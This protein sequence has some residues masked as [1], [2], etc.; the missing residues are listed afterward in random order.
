M[1][2]LI[3]CIL[4]AGTERTQIIQ[5]S[6]GWNAVYL[7]VQPSVSKPDQA[8]S[9]TPVIH[10]VTYYPSDSPVQFIQDPA[11][12]PWDKGGWNR[13]VPGTSPQA[14]LNNIYNLQANQAYL[15]LCSADYVW[16]VTGTPV[17]KSS[18]TWQPDSF[19]LVGF[20]VDETAPPT[21]SQYF[22][23]SKAHTPLKVYT[24]TDNVWVPV[25]NPDESMIVSGKA[26]WVWC[27]GGSRFPGPLQ[28]T[29]SAGN[30]GLNFMEN[31]SQGQ[32]EVMN[33]SSN[34]LSFSINPIANEAGDPDI[35]LSLVS[36]TPE[37]GSVYTPFT[38]YN[39]DDPLEN[40]QKKTITLTVRQDEMT[41]D[42]AG[43]LL[44]LA[45]NTGSVF[46]I[47]VTA[48]KVN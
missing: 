8:F 48:K 38:L 27:Q 39:S 24:L 26:Y 33:T 21:F 4:M 29:L 30:T 15:L 40:G 34:I 37:T 23:G 11:E 9:G 32:I 35:P 10:A 17:L 5:L 19:N 22:A 6:K 41:A 31:I 18:R 47:P 25:L 43:I 42:E 44:K 2:I 16:N 13:W 28:V 46:Y 14:V 36:F 7:E 12:K 3:P 1:L 45:D 20:C